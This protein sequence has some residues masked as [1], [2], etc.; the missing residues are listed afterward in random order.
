EALAAAPEVEPIRLDP[1]EAERALRT[2]AIPLVLGG[3]AELLFRFDPARPESRE[4]RLLADAAIQ[5]A[6]GG[7]RPV[8]VELDP[9]RQPGSRYIDWLIPGL[10]GLNLMSTGMWGIGFGIVYM[11]QK[12]Q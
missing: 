6:A 11:R 5:S 2:G 8:R 9:E 1:G 4:A 3:E 7:T 12:K 10:I